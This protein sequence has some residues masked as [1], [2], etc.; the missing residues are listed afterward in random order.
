MCM[1]V[2]RLKKVKVESGQRVTWLF[3]NVLALYRSQSVLMKITTSLRAAVNNS[4]YSQ[5]TEEFFSHDKK[6]LTSEIPVT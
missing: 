3:A 2:R 1:Y 6:S 5:G 4:T